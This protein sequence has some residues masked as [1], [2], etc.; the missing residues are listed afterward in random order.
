FDEDF[1]DMFDDEFMA[2]M[3][4]DAYE[5]FYKEVKAL[6]E[7]KPWKWLDD[8][9]IF[10]IHRIETNE[11]YFICVIGGAGESY[12][13]IIYE[14]LDGLKSYFQ[15]VKG[16]FDHPGEAIHVIEAIAIHYD[17]KSYLNPV[18]I[19]MMKKLGITFKGKN[20]WPHVIV[21][22]PGYLPDAIDV[23]DMS[24]IAEVLEVV[25]DMVVLFKNEPQRLTSLR[26][27]QIYIREESI[28][29]TFR[30]TKKTYEE[31][32]MSESN[33]ISVPVYVNEL[34]LKRVEKACK[35]TLDIWELDS[36]YHIKPVQD[37]EDETPFFPAMILAVNAKNKMII[38]QHITHPDD[39]DEDFQRYILKMIS[40]LKVIPKEVYMKSDRL[41]RTVLPVLDSMKI[42][43]IPKNK[44]EIIP[45]IKQDLFKR[46]R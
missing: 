18:D 41:I 14:E 20:Y 16:E 23:N 36:F 34:E 25:K 30:D 10:G 13:I 9:D 7:L 15:Q 43:I 17:K 24:E 3:A 1:D 40:E 26:D 27:D 11:D 6:G 31:L 33:E 45:D 46:K 29:G 28:G 21:Y 38:G 5:S 32:F 2:E 22:E 4:E 12:G 44:L 19:E 42:E 35:R 39:Q 37:N 8:A